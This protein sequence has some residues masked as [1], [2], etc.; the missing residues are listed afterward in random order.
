MKLV[1]YDVA[2]SYSSQDGDAIE[3]SKKAIQIALVPPGKYGKGVRVVMVI[4]DD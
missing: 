4:D 1:I 3:L 2:N